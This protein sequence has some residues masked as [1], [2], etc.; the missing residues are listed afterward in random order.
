MTKSLWI[1]LPVKDVNKSKVFF[2]Q[3]GF[4]LNLQYGSREDSAC[5]LVGESNFVVMLFEE[6]LFTS[7][8]NADVPD[9]KSG[10]EVMFSID[11]ESPEEVNEIAK[12]VTDAGGTI[13]SEP[14]E[15][16]GWMYG[17]AFQD[18]DG[19]RWNVLHMDM[20]KMPLG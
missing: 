17:C 6:N 18:L 1:N 12:K 7:L 19:H 14:Q 8:I 5:F 9:P 10:S 15:N 20:T 3:L 4:K 13:F 11:A 2:T 16:Q